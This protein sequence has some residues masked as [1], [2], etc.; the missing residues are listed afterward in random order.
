MGAL[1]VRGFKGT[2]SGQNRRAVEE[3][4]VRTSQTTQKLEG[5]EVVF[6]GPQSMVYQ[7]IRADDGSSS[8]VGYYTCLT[9]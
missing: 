4:R 7:V 8:V 5:L 2:P 3:V 6:T 9:I 1:K